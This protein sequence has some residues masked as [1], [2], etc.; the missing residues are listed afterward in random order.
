[1]LNSNK[2]LQYVKFA[3]N[4]TF[5][6]ISVHVGTVW[7]ISHGSYLIKTIQ[8]RKSDDYECGYL[9]EYGYSYYIV[10]NELINK[11]MN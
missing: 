5:R 9:N 3:L 11:L 2:P 1:M 7:N 6:Y 4:I 8:W 10:I